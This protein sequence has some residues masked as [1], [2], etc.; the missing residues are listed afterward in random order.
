MSTHIIERLR[1]KVQPYIHLPLHKSMFRQVLQLVYQYISI[2]M[3]VALIFNFIAAYLLD[4]QLRQMSALLMEKGI[5]QGLQD[6]QLQEHVVKWCLLEILITTAIAHFIESEWNTL[7]STLY[8][9]ANYA[10]GLNKFAQA[11]ATQRDKIT[12][13]KYAILY[14]SAVN[15]VVG[16]YDQLQSQL[17]PNLRNILIS[18]FYLIY[19]LPMITGILFVAGLTYYQYVLPLKQKMREKTEQ[20]TKKVNRVKVLRVAQLN[21]LQRGTIPAKRFLDRDNYLTALVHDQCDFWTTQ[22][23]TEGF[24]FHLIYLVIFFVSDP[25]FTIHLLNKVIHGCIDTSNLVSS[26]MRLGT[27]W[28][29]FYEVAS[30]MEVEPVV[31]KHKP[32]ESLSISSITLAGYPVQLYGTTINIPKG[33]KVWVSGHS[34][35]GKSAFLTALSGRSSGIILDHETVQIPNLRHNFAE[36]YQT[37]K[38]DISFEEITPRDLFHEQ[39]HEN[40]IRQM[41][42]LCRFRDFLDRFPLDTTFAS[43][44]KLSGGEKT[45]LCLAIA[46][47]ELEMCSCSYFI[48]D[49]L[50][51]ALDP[52]LAYEVLH[53]ILQYLGEKRV[54]TFI[55][56]HLE[57]PKKFDWDLELNFSLERSSDGNVKIILEQRNPHDLSF[58]SDQNSSLS[59]IK[60]S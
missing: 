38:E 45:R 12:G 53:N 46:L 8:V 10:W 58:A 4:N 32:L 40:L 29:E 23:F 54:T 33:Y 48:G 60:I 9:H 41:L 13:K 52:T 43:D 42:T 26:F 34:G 50:T 22:A 28:K 6:K 39:S 37:V 49:E 24:L 44:I 36:F 21:S 5:E 35:H 31:A 15:S 3:T 59:P 56:S 47:V 19:T 30:T 20:C 14:D 2:R 17:Y 25:V 51:D 55:V 7:R 27:D 1:K 16:L 18:L 57:Q 11:P